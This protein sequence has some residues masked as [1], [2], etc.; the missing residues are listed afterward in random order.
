MA[1]SDGR[2][3]SNFVVQALRGEDI[4]VYGSGEQTRS[5]CYISDLLRGIIAMMNQTGFTG[6]VNLG[7]P[8]EFT[9]LNLAS[10]VIELTKSRSRIIFTP[11]PADDPTQ[12]K[13]DISLAK[14][15]LGW[16]P[17]VQLEEGLARTI[18]YFKDTLN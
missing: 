7:N 3:V 12:R 11:L 17:T 15:K 13:P 4:T 18:L 6:P 2:V 10:K 9:I 5:F 16:T 8:A 1:A 14:A